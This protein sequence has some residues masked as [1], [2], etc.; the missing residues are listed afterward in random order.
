[1]LSR[2]SSVAGR[3]ACSVFVAL[4]LAG[5][6]KTPRRRPQG[7]PAAAR[8]V[9]GDDG[10]AFLYCF[11]MDVRVETYRCRVYDEFTGSLLQD[12]MFRPAGRGT[13]KVDFTDAGS[14]TSWDGTSIWF[15]GGPRL[16]RVKP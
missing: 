15:R 9:G 7:I 5:C 1:M 11:A 14:M 4:F 13:V 16:Q 6:R 10:G 12:S 8:F 2:R 3:L